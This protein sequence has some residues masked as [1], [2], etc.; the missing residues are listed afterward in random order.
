MSNIKKLTDEIIIIE[1]EAVEVGTD[2]VKLY[3]LLVKAYYKQKDI[4]AILEQQQPET[5]TI[6]D[7]D[8]VDQ[9]Q[10]Q[11]TKLKGTLAIEEAAKD[12][13]LEQLQNIA[14]IV[15]VPIK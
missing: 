15:C 10:F 8:E 5:I 13:A 3:E 6:K 9:L 1:Q 7:T 14:T 4:I 11:L 2:K 12:V